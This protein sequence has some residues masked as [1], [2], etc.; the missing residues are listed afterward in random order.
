[1]GCIVSGNYFFGCYEFNYIVHNGKNLNKYTLWL[2]SLAVHRAL[3]Y[4]N[5]TTIAFNI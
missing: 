3:Q 5:T 4:F 2:V 1:M